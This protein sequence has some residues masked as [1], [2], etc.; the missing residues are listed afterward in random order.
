MHFPWQAEIFVN[1]ETSLRSNWK[2]SQVLGYLVLMRYYNKY[3]CV[4]ICYLD[5]LS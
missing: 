5:E 1:L 4:F 2:T 3:E